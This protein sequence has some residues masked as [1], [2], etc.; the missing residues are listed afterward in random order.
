M[1]APMQARVFYFERKNPVDASR[2]FL[3]AKK[4]PALKRGLKVLAEGSEPERLVGYHLSGRH[5]IPKTNNFRN[6]FYCDR[7]GLCLAI[8]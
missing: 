2:P 6:N 8:S 7:W 4:S 1:R 5:N 3:Q